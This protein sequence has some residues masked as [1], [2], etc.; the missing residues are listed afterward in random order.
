MNELAKK[1]SERVRKRIFGKSGTVPGQWID[2]RNFYS[3]WG[4]NSKANLLEKDD[5]IHANLRMRHFLRAL[6]LE[7]LQVPEDAIQ[8]GVFGS[9]NDARLL[10]QISQ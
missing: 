1:L 6:Y 3:H 8:R 5:L 9:S 7:L 10:S 2:T 4:P